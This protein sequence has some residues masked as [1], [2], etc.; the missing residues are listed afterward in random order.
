MS[1]TAEPVT[2]VIRAKPRW[3]RVAHS[4]ASALFGSRISADLSISQSIDPRLGP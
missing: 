1:S 4:S 2:M 3:I